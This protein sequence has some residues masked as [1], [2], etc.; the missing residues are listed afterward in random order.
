MAQCPTGYAIVLAGLPFRPALWAE[1]RICG[2]PCSGGQ[3]HFCLAD[4]GYSAISYRPTDSRAIVLLIFRTS[5]GPSPSG[6]TLPAFPALRRAMVMPATVPSF[7][8]GGWKYGGS[9]TVMPPS[10][11]PLCTRE[12]RR[13][14]IQG[15][16]ASYWG[17]I[18][19][20]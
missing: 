5:L 17:D 16:I 9:S 2:I 18:P 19:S 14:R 11:P 4:R 8:R 20:I 6:R 15:R 3:R 7:Q 10:N 12:P 13:R 1:D